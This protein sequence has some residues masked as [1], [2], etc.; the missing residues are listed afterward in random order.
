MNKKENYLI[1]SNQF[2][3]NKKK[4]KQVLNSAMK[5][6][7]Y[8]GIYEGIDIDRIDYRQFSSLPVLTKT[9]LKKHMLKMINRER[10]AFDENLYSRLPYEKKRKYL[11][12]CGME[13]RV[14]SGST[15]VPVEVLK[16]KK[17]LARDY[18]ILNVYRRKMTDYDFRGRFLWV[19][20]VN[21]STKKYFYPD[22]QAMRFWPVNLYGEQ[23]MMYTYSNENLKIMY[24]Y[25][26]K[27]QVEWV[28]ISPS[29]M[30]CFIEYIERNKLP[31]PCLKYIEC[32]SEKLYEW[33]RERIQRLF[34][35]DVVSIY[36]SN[37][38]Q[39]I[40]G[41]W[42][43]NSL[44]L[45]GENAFLELIKNDYGGRNVFVTSLNYMDIPIIRYK[46]GD[47]GEWT[48]E[49]KESNY[50]ELKKYREND[51]VIGKDG[52]KYE[53]FVLTDSIILLQNTF[54]I[55]INKYKIKQVGIFEFDY[56]FDD[57]VEL[58]DITRGKALLEVFLARIFEEHVKVNICISDI[59][60]FILNG[61]KMK[62]IE[63]DQK[64][65]MNKERL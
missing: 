31:V 61:T 53:S 21:P 1:E 5:T 40:A 57:T 47:C 36:S 27:N 11:S 33:Q 30:C 65:L 14:T 42:N 35:C 22:E 60:S 39:F 59:D 37:E 43:D 34:E 9:D 28:T 15:G 52:N 3:K 19:W 55:V 6:E 12:E 64:L 7:F 2:E 41:A 10:I 20:P 25:I 23:Y 62:Y 46:L 56:C 17:D 16:S 4:I 32:H 51:Y 26:I 8:S 29:A 45:F 24:E 63:I 44:M 38:V 13:L 18:L 49:K 50:F 48:E 58:F 54:G